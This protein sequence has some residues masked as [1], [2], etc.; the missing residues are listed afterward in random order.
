VSKV[1]FSV[2]TSLDGCIA[3]E[4]MDLAHDGDPSFKDWLNQWTE[5]QKWLGEQRFFRENL[6]LG[7]GGETG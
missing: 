3:P 6:K 4:G 1:F 2:T 7:D 5:L